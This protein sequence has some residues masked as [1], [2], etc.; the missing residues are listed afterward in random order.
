[1]NQTPCASKFMFTTCLK[2]LEKM[3][4]YVSKKKTD[5]EP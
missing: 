2:N 3:G 4:P 1:M 5:S